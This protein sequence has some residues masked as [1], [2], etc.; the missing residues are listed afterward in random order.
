MQAGL[1][2]LGTLGTAALVALAVWLSIS[3]A[4]TAG[5]AL[6]SRFYTEGRGDVGVCRGQHIRKGLDR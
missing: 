5:E 2:K 1:V 6:E 4:A 3:N